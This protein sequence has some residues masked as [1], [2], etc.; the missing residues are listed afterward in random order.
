MDLRTV[1]SLIT[2]SQPR[3]R[4]WQGPMLILLGL[5]VLLGAV[6]AGAGVGRTGEMLRWLL[7][8]WVIVAFV[9]VL[10]L[11]WR[12]R[13]RLEQRLAEAMEAV[14]LQEW[15][16]AEALLRY[17]LAQPIRRSTLRTQALL[18]LAAVT[19]ASHAHE[20]TEHICRHILATGAGTAVQQH[21]ACVGLAG[22]LLRTG[23]ITDAVELVDRLTR[24][25]LP[26]SLRAQVEVLALFREVMMGHP[27][28]G[29]A[30]ADERAELFR[31]HLGTHAGYGYG[32]LAAAFHALD[33]PERARMYW[34]KATLLIP[35][36]QLVNRFGELRKIINRYPAA[37]HTV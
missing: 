23:Q 34:H 22:A 8:Q 13:K 33:Q 17:F 5:S 11:Q 36:E 16:R 21:L 3:T 1:Q 24:Q 2:A 18:A 32:L 30:K 37:E 15:P 26:D 12:R 27:D 6:W 25:T 4:I 29:A 7:P 9:L 19:E 20:A 31:T 10:Y 35:A 28:L 14:R